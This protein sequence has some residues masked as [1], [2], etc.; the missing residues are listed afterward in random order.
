VECPKARELQPALH[1]LPDDGKYQVCRADRSDQGQDDERI[2][3]RCGH[4]HVTFR[5]ISDLPA[6]R[7]MASIFTPKF[8]VQIGVSNAGMSS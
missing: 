2:D 8:G 6:C 7:P 3:S 5:K 1:I 4:G